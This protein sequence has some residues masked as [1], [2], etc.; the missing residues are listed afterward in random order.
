M[1]PVYR[2]LEPVEKIT[3]LYNGYEADC[4]HCGP[5]GMIKMARN[6]ETY[7][8]DP[9]RCRCL[10]CGQAYYYEKP[11]VAFKYMIFAVILAQL[12]LAIAYNAQAESNEI[13]WMKLKNNESAVFAAEKFCG[14]LSIPDFIELGM[15][16]EEEGTKVIRFICNKEE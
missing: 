14:E 3:K 9:S 10:L 13:H 5:K 15:V 8:P 1:M 2:G 7:Q 11:D 6:P 4:P 12:I 16:D